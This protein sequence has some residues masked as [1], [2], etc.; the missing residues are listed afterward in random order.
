[1]GKTKMPSLPHL[2]IM[3]N[4]N[5]APHV[6]L[7]GAGASL[8]AFP[9]GDAHGRKLPLMRNIVKVVGLGALLADHGVHEN[10]ENFEVLYDS[11]ATNNTI[12][13]N[14]SES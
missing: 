12:A 2:D 10:Y 3:R 6:V 1:M 7:L 13:P 4:I 5:H 11:L 14:C 9:S 8:A